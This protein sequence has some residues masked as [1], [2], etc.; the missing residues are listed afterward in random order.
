[1][2]DKANHRINTSECIVQLRVRGKEALIPIPIRF[3]NK[4]Q[5][6]LAASWVL[7]SFCCVKFFRC[8]ALSVWEP[9]NSC[10]RNPESASKVQTDHSHFVYGIV[11]IV[12]PNHCNNSLKLPSKGMMEHSDEESSRDATRKSS[13]ASGTEDEPIV[14]RTANDILCGRGVP[15]LNYHGNIRLHKIIDSYRDAY[16]QSD[17]KAKPAL[18]KDI[19][20][21]IKAGGARFLKRSGNNPDTWVE[22]SDAYANEKVSHALRC[23]K[24]AAK[25]GSTSTTSSAA[26]KKSQSLPSTIEIVQ[27]RQLPTQN[28]YQTLNQVS[29]FPSLHQPFQQQQ[30]AFLPSRSS[31]LSIDPSVDRMNALSRLSS[32][33]LELASRLQAAT[34]PLAYLNSNLSTL[35]YEN[36]FPPGPLHLS[37]AQQSAVDPA[38]A[39]VIQQRELLQR[40]MLLVQARL[41]NTA[42]T[43]A[44]ATNEQLQTLQRLLLGQSLT[45][46]NSSQ[47]SGG[48]SN[49]NE[50]K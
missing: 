40:Q 7:R 20:N 13:N 16:L 29:S 10:S 19:V 9:I 41:P 5:L 36:I 1:M 24:A 32:P 27:Q 44:D 2:W 4:Q 14:R 45:N 49:I 42:Q 48:A 37:G 12:I 18:V 30:H 23:K 11:P 15:I 28:L 34:N 39:S 43:S 38:I 6:M 47:T 8:Q 50:S 26:I 33:R 21:E 46:A 3:A 31:L 25:S 22:V 17:R 35:G